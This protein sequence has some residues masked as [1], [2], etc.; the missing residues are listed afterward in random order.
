M[1]RNYVEDYH[2]N[3]KTGL[4]LNKIK[5]L[6]E[7][8]VLQYNQQDFLKDDPI[9]IPRLYSK[10]E[11]IEIAGFF[12]AIFAWGQRKTIIKKSKDL[13]NRMGNTP[14]QFI[15]HHKSSDLKIMEG[16]VHR[17]YNDTDLLFTIHILRRI[18]SELG[19]IQHFFSN[20]VEEGLHK[21][22]QFFT[23][24][25]LFQNRNGKHISSPKSGSACKRLNMFLRWMVRKD[26]QNVDFGL[27]SIIKPSDLFCPLDVH[28]GNTARRLNLLH[29]KQNDW[30]ST[31]ELTKA[32]IQFDPIDP[33]KYDFALFGLGLEKFNPTK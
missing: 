13:M 32:L 22:R 14:Y 28:V 25:P 29:R 1:L 12:A 23:T 11:D 6:L 20:G 16:F 19:S 8:K 24:D 4:S 26:E 33:I 17:T 27:W 10:K 5:E 3:I 31:E 15:M 18:Y 7:Q 9:K 30:K 2:Q 21:L